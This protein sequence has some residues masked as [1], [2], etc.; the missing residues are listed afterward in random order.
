M[1]RRVGW[2]EGPV[3]FE[4]GCSHAIKFEGHEPWI[5]VVRCCWESMDW[6]S[7]GCWSRRPVG[8]SCTARPTPSW[9]AG[10]QFAAAVI[11]AEGS[12][13]DPTVGYQDRP[14]PTR[15]V[16]A[17]RKWHCRVPECERSVFTEELPEEIPAR[18]RITTRARRAAA[19]SISDHLRPVSSVA[20]ELGMDWR[21]A[22]D[23][24]VTYAE[25]V[26][27]AGPPP[28]RVLGIAAMT[29]TAPPRNGTV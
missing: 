5:R 17:Q 20:D 9:P 11:V 28:V 6:S 19:Q 27:P 23:A 25:Q 16:V 8:G 4:T 2:G 24:F 12:G 10:A 18:A 1:R 13:G 26:L 21:T 15:T 3:A 22:H 7:I 14:R 29:S